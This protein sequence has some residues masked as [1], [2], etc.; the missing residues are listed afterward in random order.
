MLKRRPHPLRCALRLVTDVKADQAQASRLPVGAS[1]DDVQVG[2]G[3]AALDTQ[4]AGHPA[5]DG[6]V[7]ALDVAGGE[8]SP[9]QL[10][11]DGADLVAVGAAGGEDDDRAVGMT[12]AAGIEI[13]TGM[14]AGKGDL[15]IEV[16]ELI[17]DD[18]VK[19]GAVDQHLIEDEATALIP[20]RQ[21]ERLVQSLGVRAAASGR[22]DA[23]TRLR[24]APGGSPESPCERRD[25]ERSGL[26]QAG[27][28]EPSSAKT[29]GLSRQ[30]TQAG[31][32]GQTGGVGRAPRRR[33]AS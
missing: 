22:E 18:V 21:R 25:S 10:D 15:T 29:S 2:G 1:G 23:L 7:A 3:A 20:Q 26:P 16:V 30:P 14:A 9:G 32:P 28:G 5:I 8:H 31:A 12:A 33:S 6:Q 19:L 11:L 13:A 17:V 27:G 4:V 24:P